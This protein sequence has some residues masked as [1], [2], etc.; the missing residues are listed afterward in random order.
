MRNKSRVP[1]K[2][3][4]LISFLEEKITIGVLSQGERIPSIRQLM[5]QFDLSYGSVMRGINYL[6]EIGLVDKQRGR[7]VFVSSGSTNGHAKQQTTRVAVFFYHPNT[8]HQPGIYSNIYLGLQREALAHQMQLVVDHLHPGNISSQ[9]IEAMADEAHGIILMGEYDTDIPNIAVKVPIVG[10]GMHHNYSGRISVL[11]I[12]PILSARQAVSFFKSKN[13]Q[14][15]VCIGHDRF[16]GLHHRVQCFMQA[17]QDQGGSVTYRDA[18]SQIKFNDELGYFFSTGHL[19]ND[20]SKE[21]QK[22]FGKILSKDHCVLSIDGKNKIDDTYHKAPCVGLD[23]TVMGQAVFEEIHYRIDN[24][25]SLPK[26]IYL[27]GRLYK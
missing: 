6:E 24:P 14:K 2:P 22:K 13:K 18:S 16:P 20:Y 12:D 9:K 17:W 15:V 25:G 11:D 27:P 3:S 1:E 19:I 10:V 26:R 8:W 5:N 23:W 4:K 7:G 21:Y